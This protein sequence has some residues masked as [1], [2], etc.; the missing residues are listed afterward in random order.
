MAPAAEALVERLGTRQ[1]EG[2]KQQAEDWRAE[3]ES[4]CKGR[5]TRRVLQI[6]TNGWEWNAVQCCKILTGLT[7]KIRKQLE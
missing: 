3:E 1:E 7:L 6:L 4:G 5:L 2:K